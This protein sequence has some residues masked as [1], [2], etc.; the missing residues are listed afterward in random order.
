MLLALVLACQNDDPLQPSTG[1]NVQVR[2]GDPDSVA[3]DSSKVEPVNRAGVV[4]MTLTGLPLGQV[5]TDTTGT[6]R[7][8][9]GPGVYQVLVTSCPGAESVPKARSAVVVRGVFAL[10]NFVCEVDAETS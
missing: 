1:L 10:V 9:V 3:V 7:V 5:F 4:V 8:N 2:R 6:A